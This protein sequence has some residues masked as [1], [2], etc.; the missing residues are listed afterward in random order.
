MK[1]FLQTV[2]SAH[3]ELPG[4][5]S[6]GD[7]RVRP[8]GRARAHQLVN[9]LGCMVL[10][11]ALGLATTT[12]NTQPVALV[13]DRLITVDSSHAAAARRQALVNY[14]WGN[15]GFPDRNPNVV[16]T[17]A[18]LPVHQLT[19]L[20][21][22]DEFRMILVRQDD[23]C[24]G[25]AQ[26]DETATGLPYTEAMRSYESHV[27]AVLARIGTGSFRLAFDETAPRHMVSSWTIE[28]VIL[29]ELRSAH[30]RRATN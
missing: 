20:K 26:H 22:A 5:P 17:N 24:F 21:R 6:P 7:W 13:D 12:G 3:Q 9:R 30:L 2:P 4:E 11:A 8:G 15:M 27:Q 23:C 14:L 16:L 18:P 29:P 10:L 25:T 19:D 1:S 28:A